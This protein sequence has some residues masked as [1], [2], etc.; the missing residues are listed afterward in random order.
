MSW[1]IPL[2]FDRPDPLLDYRYRPPLGISGVPIT[3]SQHLTVRQLH[4]KSPARARRR[5]RRGYPQHHIQA[6]D[7]KVYHLPDGSLVMHPVTYAALQRRL[8]RPR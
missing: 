1:S 4:A 2:P 7:P 6:P 8:A 3:V 5:A